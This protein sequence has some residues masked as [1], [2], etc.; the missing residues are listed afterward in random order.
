MMT[1]TA[2]RLPTCLSRAILALGLLCAAANFA[3]SQPNAGAIVL[4]NSRAADHAEFATLLEPYLTH[5]GLPYETRDIRSPGAMNNLGDA[6]LLIVGHRG[7]DPARACLS[8]GDDRAIAA[9]V[10][11]GTGLVSFDGM[12]ATWR[13]R[14][15]APLSEYASAIFGSEANEWRRESDITI[16]AS[17]GHW[18]TDL[19]PVPRSLR[20]KSPLLAPQ[21]RL[22]QNA[23]TLATAGAAD[24]LVAA[25]HGSGRAVLFTSLE[26]AKPSVLGRL[27]GMD[28]L[29]WRSLVWAARKPFVLRG[30]PKFLAF[31]VDD[32]SG[33]GKGANQ[34]LGWVDAA[35]RHGLK[36]WLGIFIDDIREDPEAIARLAKLTQ[37]GLATASPHARRWPNFFYLDEPL[38]TDAQGRNVAG[39]PWPEDVMT[40]NFAEAERF[41]SEHKLAKSKVVLPHFYQFA[42]NNFEGLARWGAEFVGTVLEPGRGY[43]T[44]VPPS[45]PYLSVEPPRP[46]SA[47]APL[48]IADWLNVPGRPQFDRRFFNFVVEIRDVT[49]YEWA[50]S[51]VS[52][53]EAIR[54]GVVQ[55]QR[56]YDSL[57]PAV[58]FT[59]ES[60]HIRHIEPAAWDAILSGVV[61]ALRPES[62]IP[63]TLDDLSRY[64]RAMHTSRVAAAR[65]GRI[66]LRGAS[67]IETRITVWEGP[68]DRPEPRIVKAPP[69]R[70][71]AEIPI[72]AQ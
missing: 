56:E 11:N 50:P 34:H 29:V 35:N 27:Y 43:G 38:M 69:F 16:G 8:P 48:F 68:S 20:L 63:V 22:H 45:A 25:T 71:S 52:V 15:P 33:F 26:W 62:P 42:L 18:I 3:L 41:W 21:L 2:M 54:R 4:V 24:L 60:D 6:A 72:N 37:T 13:G 39:R 9:T 10:A 59:H 36:P 17:G 5:F 12:L 23:R 53:E 70:G 61:S 32:V 67:D 31:R 28:D 65:D 30:M 49:G 1:A 66:T 7:L 14:K 40:A 19:R 46:S 64:M 58:L 57:L 51:G 47:P 55:S 44:H